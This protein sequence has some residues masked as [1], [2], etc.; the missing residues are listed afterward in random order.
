MIL[1]QLLLAA[2]LVGMVRGGRPLLRGPF[3]VRWPALPLACLAAQ[4]AALR[5]GGAHTDGFDLPAVIL[6]LANLGLLLMVWTNRHVPGMWFL[7][8]GLLLNLVVM[9]ANGGYMPIAPETLVRIGAH[10]LAAAPAGTRM[11]GWKDVVLPPEQAQLVAL[12]DVL[13][14]PRPFAPNAFSLG[15]VL[16]AIGLFVFV[17]RVLLIPPT[18]VALQ[19][20]VTVPGSPPEQVAPCA[21]G[22]GR[23]HQPDK[24][25]AA[26]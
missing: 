19:E 12:S 8:L 17:Q 10:D 16:I 18:A 11:L 4:T 22:T 1:L 3:P 15:D 14:L 25:P 2:I 21:R 24:S 13:V 20:A 6:L 9:L 5:L 7:G 23:P 26:P